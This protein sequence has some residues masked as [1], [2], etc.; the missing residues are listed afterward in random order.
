MADD[1]DKANDYA[2]VFLDAALRN[3][4]PKP[5]PVGVG[6]CMN[7]GVAVAGD[8]RWCGVECRD[9]WEANTRRRP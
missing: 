2:E 8:A 6:V 3:H 9:D 5:I 1:V 7:C 4:K